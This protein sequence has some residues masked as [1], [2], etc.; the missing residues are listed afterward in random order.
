[1]TVCAIHQPNF[2]PW[3]GY[4]DK[5]KN[6]DI[7]I[8]LDEVSYPKSGSGAGSWCNR[9][10]LLNGG[11][12][13]WFGLP[14]QRQSG[15][16][17][18]KDVEFANKEYNQKKIGKSLA[19]NYKN[20]PFY[21]HCL[22]L[23]DPLLHYPA[24]N[25]AEYNINA[26]VQL[27]KHLG[28]KTKFVRQSELQHQKH[29]TALLI[30]LLQQVGADTYLSGNG[31]SGYLDDLLFNEAGIKLTYQNEHPAR[32]FVKNIERDEETLS[33]LHLFMIYYDQFEV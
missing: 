13:S 17:L 33:M 15:V 30:E 12:P 14:I 31:S 27:S 3:A 9:V 2:F 18:I 1:M 22:Q 24:I 23:I 7:F 10:K 21:S 25:L 4:F 11:K 26:I 16:Q 5:I 19:Y 8:F 20:K 6:A 32:N 29:S 28:F